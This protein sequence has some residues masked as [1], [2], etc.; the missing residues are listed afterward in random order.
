MGVGV[1]VGPAPITTIGLIVFVP[2]PFVELSVDSPW[3][4]VTCHFSVCC[5]VVVTWI[6]TVRTLSS[7]SRSK[8]LAAVSTTSSR[9]PWTIVAVH[10]AGSGWRVIVALSAASLEV[11]ITS[12]QPIGL[13]PPVIVT[14]IVDGLP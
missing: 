12:M 13:V 14:S 5:P 7:V 8:L 11:S 2:R 10:L 3:W 9:P 1:G 4:P 6:A